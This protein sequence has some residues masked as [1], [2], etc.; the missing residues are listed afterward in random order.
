MKNR[1]GRPATAPQSRAMHEQVVTL[2]WIVEA[3]S[4]RVREVT[5][6]RNFQYVIAPSHYSLRGGPLLYYNDRVWRSSF[7]K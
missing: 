5:V 2:A 3:H 4:I 6:V 1:K 7:V